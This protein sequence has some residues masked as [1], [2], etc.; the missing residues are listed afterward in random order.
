MAHLVRKKYIH[1]FDWFS[2]ILT[3]MLSVLGALFIFSATY[4]P[5]QPISIFFKKQLGGLLGGV[6]IYCAAA[7][8]DHRTLLRW[9][10]VGYFLVV[11]LLL[12]TLIKGSIGM[13]AQRWISL[14]LF[15]LQPSEI[16]KVL[17]P[18]FA[19]FHFFS[20]SHNKNLSW[21]QKFGPVLALLGISFLLI[22]KQPDLG[23]A[24][25]LAFSGFILLWLAGMKHTFFMYGMI[26]CSLAAPL[27]WKGLKPYQKQRIAVFLGYGESHKERYQ[28]EQ[29]TIAIGSG[30]MTGKGLLQ[31][32]QNTLQFLPESRTDFIFAV[33]AEEYGFIGSLLLLILYALLFFRLFF[34]IS[35]ITAPHMQLLAIGI[36]LQIMLSTLIN[37]GMVLGLL[38]IVGIPLPLMSYGL[39]NLWVTLAA[40]GWL[41]GIIMQEFYLSGYGTRPVRR[42]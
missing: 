40:L 14:G 18:A 9:G 36:V 28:I 2:F 38:P 15:K 30:G 11:G 5:E 7:F 22:L 20:C 6:L 29:A 4:T 41:Q 3:L 23:T 37:I 19:A 34:L 35:S 21:A 27:L 25:V 10:Y 24:L 26:A 12:F 13:G 39:S 8:T 31:G 16:A 33:L 17:F 42:K 1:H 32:T